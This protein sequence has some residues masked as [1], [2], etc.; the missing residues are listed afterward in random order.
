MMILLSA[1]LTA[2]AVTNGSSFHVG[3]RVQT[4][5]PT[6]VWLNPPVAGRFGG[7][8]PAQTAGSIVEG[9]VRA[10]DVWWWKIQ[11]DGGPQGW[12]A[13]RQ[14]ATMDGQFAGSRLSDA[15]QPTCSPSPASFV[16]LNLPNGSTVNL[17]QI[18]LQGTVTDDVYAPGLISFS[19][20][21]TPIALNRNGNFSLPVTLHPGANTF[22]LQATTPNPRQQINKITAFLD[23]SVI[24]GSDA[25]RSAA[26]RTFQGGKLATSAGNLPPLNS[27]G[28]ANA[29]DA[30][31]FP[32][33]ELFL[34]GDVRANE[35]VELT[36]I[37]ALFVRE[38]NQIASAFAAAK[39]SLTDE[40]I[41]QL[42]RRIVVAEMQV[43][44]YNEF[45]PA[46]LGPRAL[47]PYWGYNPNVNPGIAT[48]FSTGAFRIGHTLVNGDVEFLDN[49]ANPIRATLPLAEAFFNP[50]PLKESGPDPVL[51]YLS[52]DNAQE[53]DTHIVGDLRNFLFGPPGAGGF[54]L[55]SLNIQRGRDHG[56]SDYNSVRAAYGLPRVTSFSQIT[57]DPDLQAKL[58]V[59]YGNV[60]SIDLW[61]GGL[62]EDHLPNASVGP[63]FQRIIANQFE[64]VRDADRFWYE[65]VFWGAQLRALQQTRLSDIIRRNT[66]ITK[67]QDNVFFFEPSVLETLQPRPGSLPPALIDD[68]ATRFIVPSLDGTENNR[69]HTNWGSTG[70]DLMRFSPAAYTDSISGPAGA[71]RP[72]ARL[73]SN[74][75]SDEPEDIPN[76]RNMSDWVYGWGQFIDHDLD[77]TTTGDT[78]FDI[79]VPQGDPSFDPTSTGNAVIYFSRS[80][81][82]PN[83]GTAAPN[84]HQEVYTINYQPNPA[85]RRYHH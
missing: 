83:T 69:W 17:S 43:I 20:N 63:T 75:V 19:V 53:V 52:T 57:S 14:L 47:R 42:T 34:A 29:N 21:G 66:T 48:E 85:H 40:Q 37:H 18:L 2:G 6:A 15:A 82:D 60:D 9:P 59:L 81:Y 11:F 49:D 46:L 4:T 38:H 10:A 30:H 51:K 5:R 64:R 22:T 61:V 1:M 79:P 77:L 70:V 71:T 54:D 27:A 76:A 16:R 24:Y 33:N 78:A 50:Q 56:L 7:N 32:D 55:A 80:I 45:L 12:V 62:A 41:F 35:N 58:F 67:L 72:G 44:T 3:D 23:G 36:A 84:L 65:R 26:L 25:T 73:I 13:E 28:L 68:R 39:S 31:L 8:Q 74:T